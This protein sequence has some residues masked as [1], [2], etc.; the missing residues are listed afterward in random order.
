[1][2]AIYGINTPLEMSSVLNQAVILGKMF[3]VDVKL[4]VDSETSRE[5]YYDHPGG[6][7]ERFIPEPPT[8]KSV[9][10]QYISS[11]KYSSLQQQ[12]PAASTQGYI[13]HAALASH[14]VKIAF[15]N[16]ETIDSLQR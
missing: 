2:P 14:E 5:L 16:Y 1:M 12:Q 15:K 11:L 4:L 9:C 6:A 10:L 13:V 8:A 7:S 3:K